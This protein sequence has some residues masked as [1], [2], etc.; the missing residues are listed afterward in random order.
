[1]IWRKLAVYIYNQAHKNQGT[2]DPALR[3]VCCQSSDA[4]HIVDLIC[5]RLVGSVSAHDS[6]LKT[7]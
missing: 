2:I 4:R 1:M 5:S 6:G 7:S 3:Y